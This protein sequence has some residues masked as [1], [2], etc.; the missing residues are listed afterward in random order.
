MSGMDQ[1]DAQDFVMKIK[2]TVLVIQG[3]KNPNTM[4]TTF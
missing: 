4:S 1:E 3:Y 2:V